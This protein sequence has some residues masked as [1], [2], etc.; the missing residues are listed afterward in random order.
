MFQNGQLKKILPFRA[1]SKRCKFTILQGM[2]TKIIP[3]TH[4]NIIN[5]QRHHTNTI[6]YPPKHSQRTIH[7]QFEVNTNKQTLPDIPRPSQVLFEDGW[8]CLLTSADVCWHVL[9]SFVVWTF[10]L[11]PISAWIVPRE[12]F[13]GIGLYLDGVSG[14]LWC[15]DVFEGL[16]WCSSLAE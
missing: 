8:K 9:A 6:R 3:Q 14:R 16:S 1:M 7:A 11:T 10:L 5:V 13:G 2:S 12:C 15:S 4:P